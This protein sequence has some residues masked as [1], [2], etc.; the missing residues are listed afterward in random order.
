MEEVLQTKLAEAQQRG[1]RRFGL[2]RPDSRRW[3]SRTSEA[4]SLRRT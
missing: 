2:P 1:W 4:A 3:N